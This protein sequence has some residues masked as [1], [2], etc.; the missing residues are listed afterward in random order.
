[1]IGVINDFSFL[2]RKIKSF[3]SCNLEK[4]R[5]MTERYYYCLFEILFYITPFFFAFT[6]F[7][8]H[9]VF[10]INTSISLINNYSCIFQHTLVYLCKHSWYQVCDIDL[11]LKSWRETL[12]FRTSSLI[13]LCTSASFYF[14][15]S[16]ANAALHKN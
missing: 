3:L 10:A 8:I 13:S 7:H 15:C 1:M 4:K 11:S 16:A 5:L 14:Q 12:G 6:M 2:K 9:L